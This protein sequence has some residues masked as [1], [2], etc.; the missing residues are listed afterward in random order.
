M[1]NINIENEIIKK[2]IV[3]FHTEVKGIYGYRRMTMNINRKLGKKYNEKRIY[4]LMRIELKISSCIRIKKR[5]YIKTNMRYTSENILN[6]EFNSTSSAEKVL[7][8]ITE[9]KYGSNKKAYLC[10]IY[11]LFDKSIISY[12]LAHNANT[13]LVL[14]VYKKACNSLKSPILL[15]HSDRGCQYTSLEFKKIL[16]ENNTIHS[17]SRAG[18]CIDNGPMEG[19]FGSIKSEK[20]YLN[21]YETYQKLEKDIEDYI[22]FYNE[23]RLQK[24]LKCLSPIEFRHFNT[25]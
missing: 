24:N 20:Y 8:D 14:D 21:K 9:F 15:L 16:L 23:K 2:E 22:Q 5:K 17:M 1:N 19:F 12:S 25:A 6:R 3:T 7:T 13:S 4:R 10:V 18:K 11:D